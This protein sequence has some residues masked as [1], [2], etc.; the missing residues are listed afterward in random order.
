M[1]LANAASI[2]LRRRI[3]WIDT[4][5]AG[6]YHWTTACR[7]AEEAE[8]AL[9]TALGIVDITFGAMPRANVNFDFRNALR[10]NEPVDV[11]LRVEHLGRTSVRY[12]MSIERD[13]TLAVQGAITAVFV[14]REN[15][16]PAPWPDELRLALAEGGA[17]TELR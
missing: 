15:W 5:A 2:A 11:I 12:A 4:D 8:S 3:G 13:G 1:E 6:I 14:S 16:R 7:L 10:F 9:H 17:Q